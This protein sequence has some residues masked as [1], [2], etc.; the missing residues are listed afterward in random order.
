MMDLADIA[1]ESSSMW[2]T[3]GGRIEFGTATAINIGSP[4][5]VW[6]VVCGTTYAVDGIGI[7]CCATCG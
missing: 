5:V 6:V 7:A 1:V 4:L 2:V 3:F